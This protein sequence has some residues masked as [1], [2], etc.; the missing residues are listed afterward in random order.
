VFLPPLQFLS[1]TH[2]VLW[3]ALYTNLGL[4]WVIYGSWICKNRLHILNCFL[5]KR[6]FILAQVLIEVSQHANMFDK[7]F[8][9]GI[10]QLIEHNCGAQCVLAWPIYIIKPSDNVRSWGSTNIIRFMHPQTTEKTLKRVVTNTGRF[11]HPTA[12]HVTESHRGLFVVNS[13]FPWRSSQLTGDHMKAC[14]GYYA[15]W[16]NLVNKCQQQNSKNIAHICVIIR[17]RRYISFNKMF[18]I[19]AEIFSIKD[20]KLSTLFSQ[21]S[22]CAH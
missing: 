18:R 5:N 12:D 19:L 7:I 20:K 1:S 2:A 6:L 22:L 10:K 3:Y 16:T 8:F 21:N 9:A 15:F 17:I 11:M 14:K 4:K 13:R